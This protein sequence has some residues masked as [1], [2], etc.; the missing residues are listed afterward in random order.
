MID[1][2]K[3]SHTE[4]YFSSLKRE[5]ITSKIKSVFSFSSPM[6]NNNCGFRRYS[7]NTEIY[8]LFENEMCLIIDYRFVDFLN[9]EYRKLAQEEKDLY[10]GLMIKDFFNT[11]NDIYSHREKRIYQ[12]QICELEYGYIE[13]VCLRSVTDAYS[14]WIDDDLDYVEPTEETFDEIKIIMSIVMWLMKL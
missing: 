7:D 8:V 2:S 13:N 14:K 12:V 3:K 1:F 9:V 11:R 4:K 10:E 6:W 5:F